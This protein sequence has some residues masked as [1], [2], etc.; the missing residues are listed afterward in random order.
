MTPDDLTG[1]MASCY[2]GCPVV[3]SEA[4]LPFFTYRGEGSP[5]AVEGCK[6][7]GINEGAHHP[8]NQFTGREGITDHPFVPRG[9]AATD[10]YYCGCGGWD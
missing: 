9:P 3:P 2:S 1:R 7:C 10:S 6:T 8:I 5:F 4:G